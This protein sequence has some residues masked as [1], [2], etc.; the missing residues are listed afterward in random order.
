MEVESDNFTKANRTN[1]QRNFLWLPGSTQQMDYV[2]HKL[3]VNASM[4]FYH[5][6]PKQ[7]DLEMCVVCPALKEHLEQGESQIAI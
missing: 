1:Y 2:E 3:K 7:D 4:N 6:H 5:S